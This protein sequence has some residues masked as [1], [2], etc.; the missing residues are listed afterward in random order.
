MKA[1]RVEVGEVFLIP[2]GDGRFLPCQVIAQRQK[3]SLSIC[4]IIGTPL[5]RADDAAA[6]NARWTA[7]DVAAEVTVPTVNLIRHDGAAWPRVGVFRPLKRP[8]VDWRER[9]FLFRLKCLCGVTDTFSFSSIGVLY[10]TAHA[11]VGL[12]PWDGMDDPD[13]YEALLTPSGRTRAIRTFSKP[14]ATNA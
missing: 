9:S 3:A 13:Y 1:R 5:V 7:A 8:S 14:P 6:A 11:L 4:G 2:L 12:E 10:A